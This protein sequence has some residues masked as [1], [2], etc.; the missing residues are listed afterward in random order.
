VNYYGHLYPP[1]NELV[2][3]QI[4]PRERPLASARS[5]TR[6]PST[7][8]GSGVILQALPI[9][10][11]NNYSPIIAI[12]EKKQSRKIPTFASPL[13]AIPIDLICYRI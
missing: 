4:P 11:L 5:Q 13:S 8:T 12:K 2:V 3:E 1:K 10:S 6:L 7:I 9:S